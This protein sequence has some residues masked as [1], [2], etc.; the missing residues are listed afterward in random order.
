M[1]A[2][3]EA[4]ERAPDGRAFRAVSPE[5]IVKDTRRAGV[6]QNINITLVKQGRGERPVLLSRPYT[7]FLLL[8]EHIEHSRR[9]KRPMCA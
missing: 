9:Q 7:L 4:L 6:G 2:A 5:V 8:L 1:A 3:E